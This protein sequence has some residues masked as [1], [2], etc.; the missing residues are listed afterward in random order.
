MASACLKPASDSGLPGSASHAA[1]SSKSWIG[2]LDPL[3]HAH[4]VRDRGAAH[5]EDAA[6]LRIVHLDVAGG[7]AQLHRRERMHRDAGRA[8]RMT[9]GLQ[10]ARRIDRQLAVLLRPSFLDGARTL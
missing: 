4:I 10:P 9:L 6:E 1:R 5:V 7:A 2:L 8:D 3:E